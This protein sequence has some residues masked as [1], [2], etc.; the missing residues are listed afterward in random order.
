MTET[1]HATLGFSELFLP[2]FIGEVSEVGLE[3]R[4]D[5]RFQDATKVHR[6][7][8]EMVENDWSVGT[9]LVVA[10]V[11]KQVEDGVN[12]VFLLEH[13]L[14]AGCQLTCSQLL[15]DLGLQM[16]LDGLKSKTLLLQEQTFQ[17]FL[18]DLGYRGRRCLH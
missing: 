14:H 8:F 10:F 7:E 15:V 3:N 5:D 12:L 13:A 17:F 16:L 4:P 9:T 18:D 1:E 6:S 2:V 11:F